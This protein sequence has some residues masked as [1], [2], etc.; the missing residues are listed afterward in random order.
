MTRAAFA[1]F[2]QG[3]NRSVIGGVVVGLVTGLMV[4]SVAGSY[5]TL[6]PTAQSR[7]DLSIIFGANH[8][9]SALFGRAT[10]LNSLGGFTNFKLG[11]TITITIALWALLLATRLL[12][13]EEDAGRADW[14]VMSDQ[15]RRDVLMAQMASMVTGIVAMVVVTGIIVM[16]IGREASVGFSASSAWYFA[17]TLGATA[18]LFALVGVLSSQFF[19]PRHRAS[20]A[21]G[22][23]LG[24]AYGIR[25]VGDASAATAWVSWLSPLGWIE[26]LN[27]F[28]TTRP[29]GFI[30]I[31]CLSL[32][33]A[34]VALLSVTQRD[35]GAG[36]FEERAPRHVRQPPRNLVGLFVR[37]EGVTI[38]SWFI[39]LGV[40]ALLFGF[41]A[42]SAGTVVANSSIAQVLKRLG[43]AASGMNTYLSIAFLIT[44]VLL[45]LFA[46][47]TMAGFSDEE[48]SGRLDLVATS[49]TPRAK[50]LMQRSILVALAVLI[51]SLLAGMVV[52]LGV[53]CGGGHAAV[54][55]MI[56]AGL[57]S[58]SPALCLL[59]LITLIA[60][61]R[62]RWAKAAGP[63]LVMASFVIEVA[64]GIGTSAH[65]L[66]PLSVFHWMATV[67]AGSFDLASTAALIA[68]GVGAGLVGVWIFPRRD[69]QTR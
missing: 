45:C 2:R 48:L 9:V 41:V 21:G 53:M 19:A 3:L 52:S 34:A 36:F 58:A 69:L 33:L 54:F 8:A 7:E 66:L 22:I 28:V 68:I 10:S 26:S 16:A 60:A 39:A 32:V 30:P 59:G 17:L 4:A 14:L 57:V 37:L 20:R 55:T 25:M 31:A 47:I 65:G 29:F 6:Y 42:K 46:T 43:I 18:M 64:A 61:I 44:S 12:R 56:E 38:S 15:S 5:N 24:V 1:T 11:T 62:P 67:P 23:V 50:L 13:G 40:T 63:T 35:V 51:G 49:P 27:P